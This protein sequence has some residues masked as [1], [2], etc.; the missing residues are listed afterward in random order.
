[1]NLKFLQRQHNKNYN[2]TLLHDTSSQLRHC[3]CSESNFC[4]ASLSSPPFSPSPS[5]PPAPPPPPPPS[6]P[7]LLIPQGL[8]AFTFLSFQPQRTIGPQLFI[9]AARSSA[10][11]SL[12]P[13]VDALTHS[14]TWRRAEGRTCV[15]SSAG[16][17]FTLTRTVW[18][19]MRL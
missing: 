13:A 3:C 16:Y 7:V 19:G 14:V 6:S 11:F 5:P 9:G 1:M 2:K 15:E 4:S 17:L 18:C 12:L 8:G 10:R